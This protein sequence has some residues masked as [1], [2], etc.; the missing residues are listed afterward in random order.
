MSRAAKTDRHPGKVLARRKLD[1]VTRYA[2]AH[3]GFK[4]ALVREMTRISRP[5]MVW[6]LQDIERMFCANRERRVEPAYGTGL[7]LMQAFENIKARNGNGVPPPMKTQDK[8]GRI[9]YLATP[10][11]GYLRE[12]C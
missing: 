2:A 3:Y 5:R 10:P 6:I 4:T 12:A 1:E 8:H 7:L 11:K 9:R